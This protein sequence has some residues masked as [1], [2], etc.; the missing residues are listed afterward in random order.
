MKLNND[1]LALVATA[2]SR[3][4]ENPSGVSESM[5]LVNSKDIRLVDIG[6]NSLLLFR[7]IREL[8]T[9]FEIELD[10]TDLVPD[11]FV[12]IG[13][14]I[15]LLERYDLAPQKTLVQDT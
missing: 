9:G 6:V 4:V 8:E 13:N 3:V 14:V 15:A 11:N 1:Q 7:F 2:I 10:D 12:T 5:N